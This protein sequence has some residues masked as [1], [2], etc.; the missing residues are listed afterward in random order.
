M[1]LYCGA[2]HASEDAQFKEDGWVLF[3]IARNAGRAA[4]CPREIQNE[5]KSQEQLKV[6]LTPKVL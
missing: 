1:C 2:D 3:Q 6:C 4:F 5:C